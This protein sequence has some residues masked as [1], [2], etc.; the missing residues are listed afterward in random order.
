ML[1]E[2]LAA[3]SASRARIYRDLGFQQ[4]ALF[5][6]W[7]SLNVDPSSYSA[8]RFLSDSYS[9]LPRHEIAR[10][11]ELL[12]SQLLQPI[13]ITPVQPQLAESNLFILEGAGPAAAAFNEFNP[14]FNRNRLALQASGILADKDTQGDDIVQ[15][16]VLGRVSYSLSQ[17]HYESD[18]FRK[19]NNLNQDIY[20]AFFQISL[21]HKTSIQAEYRYLDDQ[22]GDLSLRFDPDNFDRL[23]T[24][25]QTD[26]IRLG[27]HH[28]FSPY[29]ETIGSFIYQNS[30]EDTRVTDPALPLPPSYISRRT[31]MKV[32]S[33]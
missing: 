13:N 29:S 4:R 25:R 2:D 18:G 12:Q 17:Y 16:G 26:T 15:S 6:G 33:R 7:R 23:S 32:R 22:R 1:D 14:L 5:E 31:R 8:H 3:R 24:K 21:S 19:N 28:S 11:S 20:D 27:F 30:D 9:A 10:V